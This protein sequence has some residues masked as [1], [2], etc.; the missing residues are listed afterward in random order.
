MRT[1]DPWNTR[2]GFFWYNDQEIFEFTKKDFDRRAAAL[3]PESYAPRR[4]AFAIPEEAERLPSHLI[5]EDIH[6]V[7]RLRWPPGG[8]ASDRTG[9]RNC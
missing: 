4:L 7:G 1:P 8:C 2:F 9:E 3:M 6:E 5:G